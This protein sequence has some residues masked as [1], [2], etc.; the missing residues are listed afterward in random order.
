MNTPLPPRPWLSAYPPGTP[1]DIDATRDANLLALL[2]RTTAHRRDDVAFIGAGST[3]S[4]GELDQRARALAAWLGAVAGLQPGDRVAVML[5]NLTAFPICLLGILRAGG[6]QVSVNPMYTPR[7]LQ[8]QLADSGARVIIAF[9]AVL[10]TVDAALAGTAVER[11]VVVGAVLVVVLIL[12]VFLLL[13]LLVLVVVFFL[14]MLLFPVPMTVIMGVCADAA[15][16]EGEQSFPRRADEDLATLGHQLPLIDHAAVDEILVHESPRVGMQIGLE[17]EGV[18]ELTAPDREG[19]V[20]M[21]VQVGLLQLRLPDVVFG[22]GPESGHRAGHHAIEVQIEMK[23]DVVDAPIVHRIVKAGG[24]ISGTRSGLE[25]SAGTLHEESRKE[26]TSRIHP[27]SGQPV[28]LTDMILEYLLP[29]LLPDDRGKQPA[30]R[31]HRENTG[32]EWKGRDHDG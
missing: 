3:L 14:P 17:S 22:L 1:A 6:V 15:Q 31:N 20:E 21:P 18:L 2:E 13:F 19:V 27:F 23:M 32:T 8:H 26:K 30:K 4:F 28:H 5:P 12:L 7:E 25:G 9:Q 16:A 10:P 29:A 24:K 11:V